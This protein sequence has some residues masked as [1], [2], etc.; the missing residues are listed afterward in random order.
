MGK[1]S[2]SRSAAQS[3]PKSYLTR[4][5]GP[6]ISAAGL[7]ASEVAR[8]PPGS[9]QVSA[10]AFGRR[11]ASPASS[12]PTALPAA[13]PPSGSR[14]AYR[15]SHFGLGHEHLVGHPPDLGGSHTAPTSGSCSMACFSSVASPVARRGRPCVARQWRRYTWPRR[16][17][18]SRQ[19]AG[20]ECPGHPRTQGL[21]QWRRRPGC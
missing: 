12:R 17:A 15:G 7:P 19:P 2:L 5:A 21:P 8:R 3:L 11:L 16:P 18:V 10:P 14:L 1:Q 13:R 9:P 4:R 6:L 20:C